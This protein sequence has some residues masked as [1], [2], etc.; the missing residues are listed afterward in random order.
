MA[1]NDYIVNE[2]CFGK[3]NG[4]QKKVSNNGGIIGISNFYDFY[5]CWFL[6]VV[7]A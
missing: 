5:C 3:G 4:K 6:L 2:P 1:L 7:G